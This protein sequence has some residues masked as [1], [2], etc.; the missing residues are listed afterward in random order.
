MQLFMLGSTSIVFPQFL[1]TIGTIRLI[2]IPVFKSC[3][4]SHHLVILTPLYLNTYFHINTID[5]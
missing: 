4:C 2:A 1:Q 3:P 5:F